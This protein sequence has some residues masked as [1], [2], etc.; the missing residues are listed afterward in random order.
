MNDSEEAS[1]R[2][3]M[4]LFDYFS[5]HMTR[6]NYCTVISHVERTSANSAHH[7]RRSSVVSIN[8][9]LLVGKLVVLQKTSALVD[10]MRSVAIKTS[11]A[12]VSQL[13]FFSSSLFSFK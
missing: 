3:V 11:D 6:F 4:L 7:L 13:P 8:I 10:G 1:P 5:F 2:T 9:L 12:S